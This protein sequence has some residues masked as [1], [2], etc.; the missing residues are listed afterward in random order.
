MAAAAHLRSVL[1]VG[2][3]GKISIRAL[4]TGACSAGASQ[5]VADV[6]RRVWSSLYQFS[7]KACDFYDHGKTILIMV[8][9]I[10]PFI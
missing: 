5:S 9:A 6:E 1:I 8:I 7:L 4:R 2:S 10:Q 3:V